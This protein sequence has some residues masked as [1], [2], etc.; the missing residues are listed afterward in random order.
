M[1]LSKFDLEE[2]LKLAQKF[3]TFALGQLHDYYYP[4][5]F[6]YVDFRLHNPAVSQTITGEVFKLLP[7]SW[8]KIGDEVDD[9]QTWL[10]NTASS[11]VNEHVRD[12]LTLIPLESD[13]VNEDPAITISEEA[14]WLGRLV[15]NALK[16]LTPEQQHIL[17]LRFT[18]QRALTEIAKITGKNLADVRSLQ[19]TG[20]M[21][22]R[23][24]LE[25]EA[26]AE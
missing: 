19:F 16:G 17:A 26:N 13:L 7:S 15:R 10:F 8:G 5:V 14:L 4:Q 12:N 20:L 6:C 22:L 23:Q 11:Q 18:R 2:A 25:E 1:E 9:L 21:I 24:L 3:D